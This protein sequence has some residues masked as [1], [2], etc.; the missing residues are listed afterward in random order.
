MPG[1]YFSLFLNYCV[2]TENDEN[3]LINE[4]AWACLALNLRSGINSASTLEELEKLGG[5]FF[6]LNLVDYVCDGAV[7]IANEGGAHYTHILPAGHFLLL[8]D[9]CKLTKSEISV[10]YEG[11]R[12]ILFFSE[13]FMALSGVFTNANY[14]I[15][16][17]KEC[18]IIVAEIDGFGRA[19]RSIVFGI[20]IDYK[21]H[22]REIGK[23]YF[24]AI[25]V[26]AQHFRHFVAYVH[27][28]SFLR[29]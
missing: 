26:F 3:I 16:H 18:L 13:L 27:S 8:P 12:E 9:T 6:R 21:I 19:A 25:A 11:E 17:L 5:S 10:S 2:S 28:G 24:F 22:S 14:L 23:F 15:A 20:K 1:K 29:L 7:V 4:S